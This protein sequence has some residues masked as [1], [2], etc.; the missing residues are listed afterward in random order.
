MKQR[1]QKEH[2]KQVILNE[3]AIQLSTLTNPKEKGRSMVEMLGVLAV[4]GVLSVGGIM[5][6]K[7]GMMKYRVNETI[8]ELN[9]M[10]N[11]YG[12][13]MQQMTE[14]QTLPT[15][16]ELL[17]EE[18]AVTRM[19]YGYEVLGF[20]NHFEIALFNVPNPECEQLQKTGWELPYEIKAET[21]TAENCG[22]LIYYIDNGL[23]G[24]LTEYIDSDEDDSADDETDK[25]PNLCNPAGTISGTA[26][27]C[28]EGYQGE[29]CEKCDVSKG[30]NSQS[31]TGKCYRKNVSEECTNANY[32]NGK[33]TAIYFVYGQ[34][35]CQTCQD[36]YYGTHCE[37]K[38]EDGKTICNGHGV[39]G[40]EQWRNDPSYGYGDGC[41]C[42][43]GYY[44][45]NC[46]LTDKSQEC[47]GNGSKIGY[48]YCMCLEGFSGENCEI[49]DTPRQACGIYR[50]G[51]IYN[52]TGYLTYVDG[53]EKCECLEGYYGPNC[54]QQCNITCKN[55]GTSVMKADGSCGCECGSRDADGRV[56]RRYYGNDCSQICTCANGEAYY[57]GTACTCI[58]DNGTYGPNCENS[59]PDNLC[60]NGGTARY[61][62]YKKVCE[63]SCPFGAYG[64]NCENKY[65]DDYC[66]TGVLKFD[67]WSRRYYC[68]CPGGFAG[69]FCEEECLPCGENKQQSTT[70]SCQCECK[71][72]YVRDDVGN[73]I[74]YDNNV[75]GCQNGGAIVYRDGQLKCACKMGYYGDR[76]QNNCATEKSCPSGYM[77]DYFDTETHK[78]CFCIR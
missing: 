14:E 35:V 6:Y 69:E 65:P 76:C 59:C 53:E 75:I 63:C 5:G 16:G 68:Q 15:E 37:L 21:V 60:Q 33:A 9:I 45:R 52:L 46:E 38:M 20:D 56:Y 57:D 74:P 4:I 19:G 67:N 24:T 34:C 58:C 36:G 50:D 8:N 77:V 13:Q 54:G 29:Y 51:T 3:K 27:A 48:G 26:C 78:G 32:C 61:N 42:E 17:S 10:A 62:A 47:S 43:A 55:G 30:Y 71:S 23:T 31:S 41:D 7:Y 11:T 28:K 40:T 18:N 70:S 66:G 49:K 22:E 1:I 72:G 2:Q 64:E 44:G 73:C 12:V 25:N 39:Y